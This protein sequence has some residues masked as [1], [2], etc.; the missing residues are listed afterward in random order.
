MGY[1]PHGAG[2]VGGSVHTREPTQRASV[3]SMQQ[4]LSTASRRHHRIGSRAASRTHVQLQ[5]C[6]AA[7]ARHK[8]ASAVV[9]RSM[10]TLPT[11]RRPIRSSNAARHS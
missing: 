6:S 9:P 8:R 11:A 4:R 3:A 7:R 2:T 5:A 10:H 1:D